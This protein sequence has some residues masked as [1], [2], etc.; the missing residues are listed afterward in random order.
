MSRRLVPVEGFTTGR[1]PMTGE[2][3]EFIE[4]FSYGRQMTAA[5]SVSKYVTHQQ[6]YG[7]EPQL[8][9]LQ[10][11]TLGSCA[12][13]GSAGCYSK[14]PFAC[15]DMIV[16]CR[17]PM[18]GYRIATTHEINSCAAPRTEY[19]MDPVSLSR[20]SD[21]FALGEKSYPVLTTKTYQ[22]LTHSMYSHQLPTRT[23]K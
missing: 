20:P 2:E 4:G 17:L 10:N 15:D 13:N 3:L 11:T 12:F 18:A 5:N 6:A 8:P 7:Y 19:T 9:A 23:A 16:G 21:P 22:D 1:V 14:N